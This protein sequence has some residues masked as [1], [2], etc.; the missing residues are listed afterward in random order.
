MQK[1]IAAFGGNPNNVTI[2]GQSAGGTSGMRFLSN[3]SLMQITLQ[4]FSIVVA[5]HM[6]SP[7]AKGLFRSAIMESNP[8]ALY[9]KTVR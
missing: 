1:N 2:F 7:P 6:V 9:L 8:L 3:I 5:A 4:N